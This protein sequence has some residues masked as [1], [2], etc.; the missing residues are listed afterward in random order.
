MSPNVERNAEI[1][2]R[3]KAGEYPRQIAK[4]MGLTRNVVIGVC[5]R[6]GLQAP[7]GQRTMAPRGEEVANSK[8]TEAEVRAIRA[9]SEHYAVL[10]QRYGIGAEYMRQL[11]NG[12]NWKHVA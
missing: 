10:A 7:D 8:L 4:A 12:H 6:A 9:S 11:K 5:H 2:R 3:R 1:I